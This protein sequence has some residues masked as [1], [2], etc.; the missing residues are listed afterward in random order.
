MNLNNLQSTQAKRILLSQ[1]QVK[2]LNYPLKIAIG[3]S[4]RIQIIRI[5][6]I[7][8]LEASSNYSKVFLVKD[9]FIMTSTHLKNLS[10]FLDPK[11]FLRI[12]QTYL[13]NANYLDSMIY[14][15]KEIELKNGVKLPYSRAKKTLLNDYFKPFKIN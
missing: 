15:S 2:P 9:Q 4:D 7:I 8:Y 13:I 12:H 3:H 11:I 1:R 10:K 14:S 6:D 5:K